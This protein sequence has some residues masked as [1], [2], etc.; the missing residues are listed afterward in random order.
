V[1]FRKIAAALVFLAAIAP[2]LSYPRMESWICWKE[3]QVNSETRRAWTGEGADYLRANYRRGDGIVTSFGDV[4]AIYQQ[5]G[6]PLRETYSECNGRAWKTVMNA[7]QPPLH[8][9]WAVAISGDIV[10]RA[11]GRLQKTGPRYD[12]VKAIALKGAPVIEIYRR[13]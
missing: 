6:I 4:T 5:A 7:P 2:W 13:Q 1:R 3:S 10:S 8:E 9:K 12:L 11:V